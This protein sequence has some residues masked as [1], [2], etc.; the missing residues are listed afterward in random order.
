MLLHGIASHEVT[1]NE[2]HSR[3]NHLELFS[4]E[5]DMYS[6]NLAQ[7]IE[8]EIE[9]ENEEEKNRTTEK[10]ILIKLRI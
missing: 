3:Y 6:V 7:N 10:E 2:I 1:V 9:K 8:K 5:A 4:K